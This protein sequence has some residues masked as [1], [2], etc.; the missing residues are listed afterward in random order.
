M[1]SPFNTTM[2]NPSYPSMAIK[3][4]FCDMTPVEALIT[5][6]RRY[7]QENFAYWADRYSNERS[8]QD[9]HA[10]SYSDQDYN[11]FP[12]YNALS[13]ILDKVEM[14]V[15]ESYSDILLCRQALVQVGLSAESPFTIDEKNTIAKAAIQD[16][17]DKFVDFVQEVTLG[18][19]GLVEPLPHRRRL[20][21]EEKKAVRQ[22][23]LELWNYNGDYWDPL[24]EKCPVESLFL[25]KDRI[26]KQDYHAIIE[27]ICGNTALHLLEVTEDGKDA[28]IAAIEFHPNCYETIYCDRDY[29]WVI[30]GSHEGTI[31]FAGEGLLT[32]IKYHFIGRETLFNKWPEY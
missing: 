28:E 22:K 4:L 12:R 8:G 3:V 2:T 16:E 17:R 25:S 1:I 29:R 26:T 5:A 32:F 7:C 18:E 15:G 20:K 14:L 13:A 31:T 21:I 19:L 6:A 27:F 24:D 11:L 30:Y 23:L 10:Y 9:F